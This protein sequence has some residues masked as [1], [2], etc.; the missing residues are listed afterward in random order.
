MASQ[1]TALLTDFDGT[2]AYTSGPDDELLAEVACKYSGSEVGLYDVA[3]YRHVSINGMMK[4]I[5]K[6]KGTEDYEAVAEACTSEYMRRYGEVLARSRLINPCTR[7]ILGTLK[8]AGGMKTA[9]VSSGEK[10]KLG[11]AVRHFGLDGAVD[12]VVGLEDGERVKP[13]PDLYLRALSELGADAKCSVAVED[14]AR[15]I[16]A[17]RAAGIGTVYGIKTEWNEWKDLEGADE[18]IDSINELLVL[19]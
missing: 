6:G 1:Y 19:L 5:M 7:K 9:I 10:P 8:D 3:K 18:V 15:G 4:G 13:A 2:L 17:A 14:T 11:M 16:D 12:V